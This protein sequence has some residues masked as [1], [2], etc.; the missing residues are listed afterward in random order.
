M[1]A[2]FCESRLSF[3][4]FLVFG[5]FVR[6]DWLHESLELWSCG[7]LVFWS[8]GPVTLI[9][10]FV[11]FC[12]STNLIIGQIYTWA[13]TRSDEPC[14]PDH[15]QPLCKVIAYTLLSNGHGTGCSPRVW[16]VCSTRVRVKHQKK[17]L[18]DFLCVFFFLVLSRFT[19]TDLPS[20]RVVSGAFSLSF[21]LLFYANLF[22]VPQIAQCLCWEHL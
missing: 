6:S 13:W 17:L 20:L 1:G 14:K 9:F 8:K 4:F 10:R 2:S 16:D 19:Q 15:E 5:T 7:F 22:F 21:C 3:P 12:S 11:V 18:H